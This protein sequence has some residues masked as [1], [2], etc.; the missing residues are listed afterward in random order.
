MYQGSVK[1]RDARCLLDCGANDYFLDGSY[2]KKLGVHL[3]EK[4]TADRVKLA[5]GS[6]IHSTH[7]TRITF[8]LNDFIQTE[9][10]HILKLADCDLV[11]GK[12]WLV[13]NDPHIE[14]ASGC[15]TLKYRGKEIKL[16]PR[17]DP[18]IQA[19][20]KLLI[21]SSA[22][23]KK[24][25]KDRESKAFL[26]SL[27]QLFTADKDNPTPDFANDLKNLLAEFSDVVPKM[28]NE[29]DDIQDIKPVFAD[30]AGRDVE[31]KIELTTDKPPPVHPVYRMSP[32]ELDE[33]RKQLQE[34]IDRGLIQPSTSPFGA[35]VLFVKKKNGK[36]RLVIDYR[37]LNSITV[38]D[39]EPLPR[40]DDL[41]DQ[42]HGAKVFSKIDLASGYYQVR[43]APEDTPKTAFRT[44]F[45]SFEFK[46]LPMGLCNAPST[47]QRMMN[48]VLGK[49]LDKFVLIYLDDLLV[50]SLTWKSHLEHLR[51]VLSALREHKLLAQ[52][53][54]C[55]FGTSQ[56]DFLGHVVSD[57]G[58]AVDPSKVKSVVEWP[59][60]TCKRDVLAFKGLAGFYRRFVKD[61]SKIAAPLSSLTGNVPFIWTPKEQEAFDTLK[62]ALTSAPI[63]AVPDFSKPFVVNC[64]ASS[65]AIGQV[66]M[67]GEGSEA[68]VIAYESRKL[69]DAECNY[70][71]HDKELLSI[72]HA[73]KK[74]RHYL[75]GRRFTLITDNSASKYILT[76]RTEDLNKRQI[77]YLDIFADFDM[78][79]VHRPG[80]TNIVA[81]ALSRRPD[82]VLNAVTR[83]QINVSTD[84]MEQVQADALKDP[85]YCRICDQVGKGSRDDFALREDKLYK[86]QRLYVPAGELRFKLLSEAHDAPYGGHL[87]KDKTFDR[88][89]R[90]Y[91]WPK[92]H[93]QVL[94]YCRSCPTCQANKADHQS[95]MGLL[96]PLP[97]PDKP[98][99]SVSLDLITQLPKTKDGHTAI[100]VFVD[101]CSKMILCEATTDTVDAPKLAELF[102]RA[103]FRHFGLP[104][105]LVSDR[106]PRFTSGF[107]SSLFKMLGT[108]LK[109][110][111][112]RHPQTDGQT[113]KANQ[114]LEDILRA[115]VSPYHDDWDQHLTMAEFAYNDSVNA[116]TGFTPFYL[117]HGRH[118]NTPLNLLYPASTQ[119]LSESVRAFVVRMQDDLARAKQCIKAAQERQAKY[120]DL[121]RRDYPWQVGDKAWLSYSHLPVPPAHNSKKKLRPRFYGPFPVIE[122]PSPV[123]VKLQLPASFKIHPVVHVS[124]LKANRDGS[125]EFPD[126]PAYVSPPAPEMME[127]GRPAYTVEAFRNHRHSK[128]RNSK[129]SFLVKWLGYGEHVNTWEP[130]SH[131]QKEL[132]PDSYQGLLDTYL[133]Q[134]G[135]SQL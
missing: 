38:R 2:A 30:S 116:T 29:D 43:V 49:H 105:N 18:E 4:T 125:L 11:L 17:K 51:I 109:M 44:R 118:P 131:L 120:A 80:T 78:D 99:D 115:Y 73:L 68:R 85:E 34:F 110:S 27:K 93:Q 22:Q 121:H 129:L 77:R 20:R 60:P 24:A 117:N 61:F 97:I 95:P 103:V 101:R 55:E 58:I 54:K 64:D 35:P 50:Y 63:L 135:V 87:G 128:G 12:P 28:V 90:L 134:A 14:W 75:A 69:I 113:E 81:D 86:G 39:Q 72:V 56:V 37:L 62:H 6:Y 1:G 132:S 74:W 111:T 124:N 65:H 19:L 40:I 33:L 100:V 25:L 70:P 112:S 96:Q 114:T 57:T 123:V 127:D 108:K 82:Y 76:K 16:R 104:L 8:R 23:L 53:S 94:D 98:W 41:L 32:E 36:L 122:V 83:A 9:T 67:Q 26:V 102:H 46:V 133:R 66:L 47:F 79:I 3:V 71:V 107:W 92:L 130:A 42:L 91:Y 7:C 119:H 45:G 31:H 13:K 48:R 52:A 89:S 59:V 88:L 84:F 5:D 10:F 126:R 15:I 106:D 21:V